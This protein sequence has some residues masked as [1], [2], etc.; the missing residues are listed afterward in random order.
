MRPSTSRLSRRLAHATLAVLIVLLTAACSD[1]TGPAED[2]TL[3]LDAPNIETTMS[4]TPEGALIQCV[5]DVD[6][7]GAGR[8][9]GTLT[10]AVMRLFAGPTRTTPIDTAFFGTDA[11][12]LA[13]E[14]LLLPPNFTKSTSMQASFPVPFEL[15][16][17]MQFTVNG[18]PRRAKLRMPCG[19]PLPADG[20]RPPVLA[21]VTFGGNEQLRPGDNFSV[22]VAATSNYGL[23]ETHINVEG[24]FTDSVRFL[25]YGVGATN[26][27]WTMQVPP[28]ALPEVPLIATVLLVDAAGYGMEVAVESS[29]R[30]RDLAPPTLTRASFGY[31]DSWASHDIGPQLSLDNELAI[32][33][34]A[35]D[36]IGLRWL[37]L[38][39]D[40]ATPTRDS[41][42]IING[43]LERPGF[44]FRSEWAGAHSASVHVVDR[45]GKRSAATVRSATDSLNFYPYV[46]R[47][48]QTLTL[49]GISGQPV[50]DVARD[51]FY[52]PDYDNGRILVVDA[53]AMTLL[54]PIPLGGIPTALDLSIGGDSILA[55]LPGISSI[56]IVDLRGATPN[57][58]LR[59]VRAT[60]VGGAAPVLVQPGDVKQD[61]R[62]QWI[63]TAG[64]E[65]VTADLV[66]RWEPTTGIGTWLPRPG[67]ED[68]SAV[69]GA[70]GRLSRSG[71]RSRMV[72]QY[73][74]C[75][76]IY[77]AATSTLGECRELASSWFTA[78]VAILSRNGDEIS[79]DRV[80]Y[81]RDLVRR[82]RQWGR[83]ALS[84]N[85]AFA[86][87]GTTLWI[88]E[89][90]YLDRV[91]ASDGRRLER[92]LTG[93]DSGNLWPSADGNVV[94]VLSLDRTRFV[95]VAVR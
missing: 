21:P 12:L 7:R 10:G 88:A 65:A 93:V 56:A 81:D 74:G 23:W 57:V 14:T 45:A 83:F 63:L 94:H 28:S 35:T 77:D 79:A 86:D 43:V 15:E 73:S 48:R 33:F 58:T 40:G 78:A 59:T 6:A 54:P 22:N 44:V 71:D 72:V 60:P 92:T 4:E 84:T 67:V 52:F 47:P 41:I 27:T 51:R 3:V 32:G 2:L 53:T 68:P 85:M 16:Y 64:S 34:D 75:P 80:S 36:D 25:E 87:D 76:R 37:V 13:Y 8:A 61:S 19:P 91:R 30:V 24:A 17:E 5:F 26:R 20:A 9:T 11:L 50:H 42:G 18:T 55:A 1:A 89:S 31:R 82:D 66:M 38:E 90:V 39:T 70:A 62:G 69:S 46:A 49:S 29:K 95:R